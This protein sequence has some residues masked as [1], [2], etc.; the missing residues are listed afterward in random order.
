MLITKN[1]LR[2]I[3][4]EELTK[5]MII[6][7]AR[8]YRKTHGRIDEGFITDLAK[9]YGLQK[10]AIAAILAASVAAGAF[11]PATAEAGKLM[12][13][14]PDIE[15]QAEKSIYDE[16]T[17]ELKEA[18]KADAMKIEDS[19]FGGDLFLFYKSPDAKLPINKAESALGPSWDY[20]DGEKGVLK[21]ASPE[22]AKKLGHG[23]V[24]TVTHPD[25]SFSSK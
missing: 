13:R 21:E 6:R 7:E 18:T 8:Q 2:T 20:P 10:K 19:A 16:I 14:G 11:A 22:T 3:I 24:F 4:K 15:Q 23:R 17:P 1:E 25:R 12:K 5:T 9:K